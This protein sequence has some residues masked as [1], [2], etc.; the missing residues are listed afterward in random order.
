MKKKKNGEKRGKEG[1][2]AE[3]KNGIGKGKI[4]A[5][6][7]LHYRGFKYFLI[8]YRF[9]SL[10]I[11]PP[12]AP[13]HYRKNGERRRWGAVGHGFSITQHCTAGNKM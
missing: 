2:R 4:I 7:G 8:H 6:Y 10:P 1:E 13:R 11:L 5:K 9:K 12:A 3:L